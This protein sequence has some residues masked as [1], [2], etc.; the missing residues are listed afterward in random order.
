MTVMMVAYDS[1]YASSKLDLADSVAYPIDSVEL[2][3][4]PSNLTVDSSLFKAAGSDAESGSQKYLAE[5]VPPDAQLAASL[6]GEAAASASGGGRGSGQ[7][8]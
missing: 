5:N 1:D 8:G 3:V 6:S 2:L 7:P 4:S